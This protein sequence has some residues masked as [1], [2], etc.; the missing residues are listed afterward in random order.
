MRRPLSSVL[1]LAI[2]TQAVLA[3][4][5]AIA[6]PQGGRS[7]VA[8]DFGRSSATGWGSAKT[9]GTYVL[10]G[11]RTSAA[12]VTNG[13]GIV[14]LRNGERLTA[15]LPMVRLRDVNVRLTSTLT[16][17]KSDKIQTALLARQ[18]SD[19]SGYTAR[20]RLGPSGAATIGIRRENG[21]ASTWLRG[22]KLPSTVKWGSTLHT[23]VKVTGTKPVVIRARAWTGRKI[24]GWQV[25]YT[26][27]KGA[28]TAPG[29][30]GIKDSVVRAHRTVVFRHDNLSVWGPTVASQAP[31]P[32]P[33]PSR[34]PSAFVHPGVVNSRGQLDFVKAQI[35]AGRQP[36]TSALDSA[37][38][39][40][41]S[42]REP[43]PVAYVKCGAYNN[44]DI[45]CSDE[46]A[47]AQA[48]YTAALI[49]YYTG[50][51]AYADRSIRILNA[52]S[53]VVKDHPFDK[54]HANGLLQAAWAAET[55]TKAAELI[56]YSK[57]GWKAAEITRF[58]T[59]LKSAFL[60][61]VRNGWTNCCSNWQVSMAEATMNIGVFTN[62]RAVFEDG[63]SDWRN[64][65][66]ASIYLKSD[67]PTPNLPANTIVKEST[68]NKYW[69]SP[70]SYVQG[71]VAETCR[72]L[73]H[74]A[75]TLA[76]IT[77]GAETASIQGIDLYTQ[78]QT[79]IVAALE[80]NARFL[81]NPDA[82][83]WVC[84]KPVVRGGTASE[85]TSN[86]GYSHYTSRGVS[87]PETK[88]WLQKVRNTK[89]GL[90]MNWE[91]LTHARGPV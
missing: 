88:K 5:V 11:P 91:T 85:L 21:A 28:I 59:M 75:M 80:Y 72:D 42:R 33:A 36:W 40:Y 24:P 16:G 83:G 49:W 20:V 32:T 6:A 56:R 58:E 31:A 15:K 63:L 14:K 45:G 46:V 57:A 18:Q 34:Q 77:N 82:S 66:R 3:A 8:D 52:W 86:I 53:A 7:A 19:G 68:L 55:F 1:A 62:D 48:A 9:G 78:E 81:N 74:T 23:E 76:A 71:Q 79:R 22:A 41:L 27:V 70:R 90:H 30:I 29:Y 69:F 54:N 10:N 64:H 67:G 17:R 37:K 38:R 13:R 60:P 4:G 26:D 51:Q 35:A 47:D 73:G 44:P 43:K 39:S 25:T 89:S 2:V 50:D 87:M 12:A 65:T 84:P 61:R